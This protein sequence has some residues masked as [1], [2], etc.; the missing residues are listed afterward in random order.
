M[1][2]QRKPPYEFTGAKQL[3]HPLLG[4]LDD[5]SYAYQA[6]G[7]PKAV[8]AEWEE[9]FERTVEPVFGYHKRGEE[10]DLGVPARVPV[11]LSGVIKRNHPE[12]SRRYERLA[13]TGVIKVETVSRAWSC[14]SA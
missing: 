10:A 6:G 8:Q 1:G 12:S 3:I 9:R 7:A 11:I 5:K 14:A 13:K 4:L 2:F